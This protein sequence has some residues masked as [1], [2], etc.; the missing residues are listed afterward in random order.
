MRN[1][2]IKRDGR[3]GERSGGDGFGG[4]VISKGGMRE[5]VDF[6]FHTGDDD[7]G[8]IP[9]ACLNETVQHKGVFNSDRRTGLKIGCYNF[10]TNGSTKRERFHRRLPALARG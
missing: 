3:S 5:V 7:G 6:A 1:K 9:I 2:F 8:I 4:I 10:K